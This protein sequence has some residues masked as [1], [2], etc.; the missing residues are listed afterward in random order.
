MIFFQEMVA[1]TFQVRRDVAQRYIWRILV[2]Y[3]FALLAQSLGE[4]MVGA[5]LLL[6]VLAFVHLAVWSA[7]RASA[8]EIATD[9]GKPLA[10]PLRINKNSW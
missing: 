5:A 2:G 10:Q 6:I 9:F 3:A 4:K 7:K 8:E 1:K